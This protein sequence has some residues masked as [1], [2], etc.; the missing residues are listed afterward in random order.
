MT[1]G[2][3]DGVHL[4]HQ[5]ILRQVV[6]RAKILGLPSMVM[7]FEPQPHEFFSGEK[8]PARLMRL[9]EKVEALFTSGIDRVF[10]LPFNRTLSHVPATEFIQKILVNALGVKC[11]VV[12]DD[13]R[14][15][16]RRQGDYQLLKQAGKQHGFE[17]TDTATYIVGGERVSSTRIRQVLEAA[18]FATIPSLLGKTYTTS[19]RVVRGQQLG[20]QLGAPTA[21]V[22]LHRYCS[23]LAGVFVVVTTLLNGE[24]LPGVANVGVRP[25]VCGD[26]KPILEVHLFDRSDD[27]YGQRIVVEFKH[28]IREEQ[29]FVGLDDLRQQI[30]DDIKQARA[31]FS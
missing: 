3:F 28:K 9:G 31:F 2:A 10:C 4:G 19:G 21:N 26:T 8:A 18:D 13:F 11:L 24:V 17:I 27:L 16:C 30:Q 29:R 25:T 7:I 6:E 15:G 14:F 12:G 20:K 22:H 5:A 23:P 1:I